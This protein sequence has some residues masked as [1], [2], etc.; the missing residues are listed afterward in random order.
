MLDSLPYYIEFIALCINPESLRWL[1]RDL[2][3]RRFQAPL[4]L[5]SLTR[6]RLARS[7][8]SLMKGW[9]FAPTTP[10]DINNRPARRCRFI[11]SPDD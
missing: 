1:R 11:R 7:S 6:L 10:F 9:G 8:F 3:L 2:S 4:S 5:Y